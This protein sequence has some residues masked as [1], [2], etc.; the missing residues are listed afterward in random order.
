MN[1]L[2][3][4]ACPPTYPAR[5]RLVVRTGRTLGSSRC[6]TVRELGANARVVRDRWFRFI[7][8]RSTLLNCFEGYT[9]A[10]RSPAVIAASGHLRIAATRN[11]GLQLVRGWDKHRGG[12]GKQGAAAACLPRA[13]VGEDE[14]RWQGMSQTVSSARGCDHAIWTSGSQARSV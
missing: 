9:I 10:L 14:D 5:L 6:S 3:R 12:Q 4:Q 13:P 8:S 1:R 11:T 2:R 7:I